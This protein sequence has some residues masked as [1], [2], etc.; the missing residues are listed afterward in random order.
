MD[1]LE[2]GH[3][4]KGPVLKQCSKGNPHIDASVYTADDGSTLVICKYPK[5]FGGE[6]RLH[7]VTCVIDGQPCP[8]KRLPEERIKW[9]KPTISKNRENY[10]YFLALLWGI[11]LRAGKDVNIRAPFFN[12]LGLD[13][14]IRLGK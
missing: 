14:F 8:F 6:P 7:G 5:T 11:I 2:G 4:Y 10:T 1:I 13:R 12:Y 3:W 9:K